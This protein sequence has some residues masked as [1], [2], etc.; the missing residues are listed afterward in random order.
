MTWYWR[1]S[2]ILFGCSLLLSASV[3]VNAQGSWEVYAE[4]DINRQGHDR[5]VFLET[6]SGE[7]NEIIVNGTQYTIV[8]NEVLY[9]D[10]GAHRPRVLNPEVTSAYAHPFIA[11]GG[12]HD[13]ISWVLSA[14]HRTIAWS[15]SERQGSQI[16]SH[17][18]VSGQNREGL[19]QVWME[20]KTDLRVEPVGF[21]TAVGQLILSYQPE[22]LASS[23]PYQA[24]GGVFLLDLT[25]GAT[26]ALDNGN[27]CF[28]GADVVNNTL[29][30]LRVTDTVDGFDAVLQT[31]GNPNTTTIAGLHQNN[32]TVGGSLLLSSDLEQ[33]VFV[34][35]QIN[36]LG[37][38]SEF[39]ESLLVAVDLEQN[40]QRI[41]NQDPITRMIEPIA[42]SEDHTAV[43]FS[44]PNLNGT[45]KINLQDGSFLKIADLTYIG[46]LGIQGV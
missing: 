26:L 5:I 1:V 29:L 43:L 21:D 13:S 27:E 14:D 20:Q 33:A 7:T 39:S 2:Y 24:Y 31:L 3:S 45:W 35:S 4:Y 30:R 38:T 12:N 10:V 15:V 37:S 40:I 41:L 9:F 22:P 42:W 23:Y 19:R 17:V 28:C 32:Y 18:F 44:S 25:S 16:T 8:G 34:Q 46:T 6:S 36:D 11:F